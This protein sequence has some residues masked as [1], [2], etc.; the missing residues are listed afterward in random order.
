MPV[1]CSWFTAAELAVRGSLINR[2][3]VGVVVTSLYDLCT[4]Y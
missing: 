3:L 1:V 4:P 2:G